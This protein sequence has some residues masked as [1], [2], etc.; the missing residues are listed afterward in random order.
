M[1]SPYHV[2]SW[3]RATRVFRTFYRAF[4]RDV[5]TR[6]LSSEYIEVKLHLRSRAV[7]KSLLYERETCM[8]KRHG[9]TQLGGECC[10]CSKNETE[11][12]IIIESRGKKKSL[13]IIHDT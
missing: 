2:Q 7:P 1:W 13:R 5:I 3:L 11:V 9:V 12:Y 6:F 8:R 4:Y 10:K